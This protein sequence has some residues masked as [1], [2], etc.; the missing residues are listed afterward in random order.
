VY[1]QWRLWMTRSNRSRCAD[2]NHLWV[3][4]LSYI[5]TWAKLHCNRSMVVSWKASN[6][7]SPTDAKSSCLVRGT[8]KFVRP[9]KFYRFQQEKKKKMPGQPSTI[10]RFFNDVNVFYEAHRP[11][12]YR[13]SYSVFKVTCLSWQLAYNILDCV[14][15][16]LF[17]SILYATGSCSLNSFQPCRPTWLDHWSLA[18]YLA[19]LLIGKNAS[20]EKTFAI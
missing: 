10:F 12:V 15:M 14:F 19:W 5:L 11:S 8:A 4:H 20:C 2:S 3:A 17:S 6:N 9:V 7:H 1:T 18:S 16:S 13:S